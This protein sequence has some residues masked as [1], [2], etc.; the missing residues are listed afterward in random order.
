M[1]S[2]NLG[3]ETFPPG[4]AGVYVSISSALFPSKSGLMRKPPAKLFVYGLGRRAHG[5]GFDA[6]I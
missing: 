4:L 3:F 5:F 6:I 1:P 2:R